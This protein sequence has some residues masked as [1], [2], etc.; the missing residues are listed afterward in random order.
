MPKE[1]L[2]PDRVYKACKRSV[3][4]LDKLDDIEDVKNGNHPYVSAIILDS[5]G[6]ILKD[7]NGEELIELT[8]P[9]T[10]KHAEAKVIERMLSSGDDV[11]RRAYTLITTLEPC[12]YRDTTKHPEEI[13]CAKLIIYAGIKQVIIGML[14]PSLTVR[15][16]GLALLD[17]LPV[18]YT[19]FPPD[20]TKKFRNKNKKYIDNIEKQIMYHENYEPT[21][22]PY[23]EFQKQYAPKS[24]PDFMDEHEIR[25]LIKEIKERFHNN[26]PNYNNLE[27]LGDVELDKFPKD[28]KEFA[29]KELNSESSPSNTLIK[30]MRSKKIDGYTILEKMQ[31]Y[32]GIPN[33]DYEFQEGHDYEFDKRLNILLMI[34]RW[35]F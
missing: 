28:L 24:I 15:G 25:V 16:R 3:K 18:Y 11:V 9:K 34:Y 21:I 26:Y 13:A 29:V 2:P 33:W 31:Q 5:N 35:T 30:K 20:L 7:Q 12:S 4:E 10:K 8:D 14:D 6:D 17:R 19:M 32:A 1:E 22:S 23:A 27:E